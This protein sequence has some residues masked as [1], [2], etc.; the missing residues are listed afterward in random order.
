MLVAVSWRNMVGSGSKNGLAFAYGGFQR[1]PVLGGGF[2]GN[3]RQN[4]HQNVDLGL[5]FLNP[6]PVSKKKRTRTEKYRI[7]LRPRLFPNSVS[8]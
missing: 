6:A 5:N 1:K 4:H 2:E 3:S 7:F 8:H